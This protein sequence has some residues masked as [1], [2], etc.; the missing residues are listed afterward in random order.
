MQQTH[1]Y[2]LPVQA[3]GAERYRNLGAVAVLKGPEWDDP[4]FVQFEA[5]HPRPDVAATYEVS[6]RSW[7]VHLKWQA[8]SAQLSAQRLQ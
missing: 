7:R 1:R 2:L 8:V 3:E 4:E 5:V 6:T